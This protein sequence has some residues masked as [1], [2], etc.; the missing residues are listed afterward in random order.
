MRPLLGTFVELGVSNNL[1]E[2]LQEAAIH[3]AFENIDTIQR[4]LS[5]HDSA[6]DLS[7]LNL[8]DGQWVDCHSLSIKCLKLGQAITRCSHH[9]FNFTLGAALVAKHALPD[10]H[11]S[12]IYG[13]RLLPIGNSHDLHIERNHARLR[14]PVLISLDG[15]AKGFAVD[16]GVKE[17]KQRGITGGW[18]NA[19]GDIRVFGD[20][21]LPV[22][23]RDH[24][25]K[26]HHLG[27]LQNAALA[28]STGT[29][30]LANPG[31]ILNR[32]GNSLTEATWTVIASSAWRADALTKVAASV[33]AKHRKECVRKLGGRWVNLSE[34][35]SAS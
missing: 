8:A 34:E 23:V 3:A 35:R 28:T 9:Y 4:L 26:I 1:P 5:F 16:V 27:G 10:L 6:S 11:F 22:A 31:I 19:G 30:T 15:I 33:P 14:R 2:N 13:S 12:E 32:S 25:S 18:I 7:R 21:V 29:A 17:L 24:H 20:V